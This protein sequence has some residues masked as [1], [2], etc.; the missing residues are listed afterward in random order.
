[1]LSAGAAYRDGEVAAVA[2]PGRRDPATH[3]ARDVR[4][5]RR[6][7]RVVL[8]KAD[9]L[10]VAAGEVAQ[11]R[12]PVRVGERA[13]VEHEVGVPRDAALEAEGYEADRQPAGAALLD[14]LLDDVAQCMH[15]DALGVD[16][17][18]G[19]AWG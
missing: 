11:A 19:R 7:V 16:Q 15:G 12:L 17:E 8:E 5:E 10:R 2:R 3:E 4:H 6:D 13:G 9:H 18:I 14:S 1:M